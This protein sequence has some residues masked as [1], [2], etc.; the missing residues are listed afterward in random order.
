MAFRGAVSPGGEGPGT[1]ESLPSPEPPSGASAT[2]RKLMEENTS[3]KLEG[4]NEEEVEH[5]P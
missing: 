1:P 5:Y 3:M 2:E 4:L